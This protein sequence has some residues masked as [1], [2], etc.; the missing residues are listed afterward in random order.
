[1]KT[2][3]FIGR[4]Q[5]FHNGHL[6]GIKQ[7]FE[8]GFD[9][10][11]IGVGSAQEE[12]TEKNPFSFYERKE[13][14]E[15]ALKDLNVE[16]HPIPDFGDNVKWTKYI[17][18]NLPFFDAVI[19]GNPYVEVC[20]KAH[21]KKFVRLD[22]RLSVKGTNVREMIARGDEKVNELMNEEI[23]RVLEKFGAKERL[24]ELILEKLENPYFQPS[25]TAD[26]IIHY[27]GG[28]VLIERKNDPFKGKYALPGGFLDREDEDLV[29]TLRREMRE[30]INLDLED[31][32]EV[33]SYSS[34]DRDPRGRVITVAYAARGVGELKAGDDA[35]SYK[36]VP[37]SSI[38]EM[39]LAFDHNKIVEDY[40]EKYG[41]DFGC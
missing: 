34:K 7:I 23:L 25:V 22:I 41:R 24:E 14:I 31:V 29:E 33:G 17:L 39:S 16:V 30:E 8:R 32:F 6:D 4:F 15:V 26:G 38:K 9:K 18:E 27:D 13:M 28:I 37:I 3:L 12:H 35:K 10:V 36:I 1:M 2:A 20:F 40:V 5:P 19:S 11:I 21:E